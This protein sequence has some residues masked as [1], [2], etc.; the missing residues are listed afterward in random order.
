MNNK[1]V[2]SKVKDNEYKLL[3]NSLFGLEDQ[4]EG[5]YALLTIKDDEFGAKIFVDGQE[6]FSFY[7]ISKKNDFSLLFVFVIIQPSFLF[8]QTKTIEKK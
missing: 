1:V 3:Y 4:D 8:I 6:Y 2:L 5:N 7:L